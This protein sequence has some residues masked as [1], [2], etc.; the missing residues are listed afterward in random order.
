MPI[1]PVT[2]TQKLL[3]GAVENDMSLEPVTLT[4]KIIKASIDGSALPT[5]VSLTQKLLVE[6]I[7]N[8]GGRR[9]L[10][11]TDEFDVK[12]TS[13]TATAVGTVDLPADIDYAGK[14]LFVRIRD[15]AGARD[16]YLYGSN[17]YCGDSLARLIY[18]G[19]SSGFAVSSASTNG[20]Y[21]S[22]INKTNGVP[23]SVTI[24]VKYNSSGSGTIDGTYLVEVFLCDYE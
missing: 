24:T 7:E 16:G 3:R 5:P 17:N 10:I 11:A 4:Q 13:T 6:W 18:K 19:N 14:M 2:L 8:S 1:E 9:T 23:T 21:A 15:K 20:V 12:T 22:A